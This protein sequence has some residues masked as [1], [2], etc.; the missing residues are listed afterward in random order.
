MKY[1]F[2][3]F[4]FVAAVL[5]ASAQIEDNP[6]QLNTGDN[7]NTSDSRSLR[8]NNN[9]F[10]TG[11]RNLLR[12]K[13]D[14]KSSYLQEEEKKFDMQD[15]KVFVTKKADFKP[16]Y[17][18]NGRERKLKD[19]YSKDKSFGEFT[20]NGKFVRI[21]CRDHQAVDG[22]LVRVIING[23]T[24]IDKIFLDS[25]AKGFRLNLEMGFNKIEFEALNQG[26][27]GPNTA[28]FQVY[29]DKGKTL[30]SNEWNLTT[31][32]KASLIVI[33]NKDSEVLS[34]GNSGN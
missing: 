30:L 20:N 28:A 32:T 21:V 33:K 6:N 24:Y 22:D 10:S 16:E 25:K 1:I 12:K 9:S 15:Q 7:F 27:S 5:S 14:K 26:A 34:S 3:L 13:K 11:N 31:G 17:A 2:T 8:N 4:F 18:G 23:K 29:D 19:K